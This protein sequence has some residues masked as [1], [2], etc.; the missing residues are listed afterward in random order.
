LERSVAQGRPLTETEVQARIDAQMP[1]TE[2]VKYAD[3]VIE[4]E[5][6]LEELHRQ[7]DAL[8]DQLQK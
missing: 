2:K 5:G 3:V 4:N 8:W 6:T 1:V 7:V